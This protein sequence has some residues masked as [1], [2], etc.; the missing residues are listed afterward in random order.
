M[1]L[2]PL[3]HW[4]PAGR[5]DV[6]RRDGL[7]PGSAPT[8]ASVAQPHICLS[9]DPGTAWNVSGAREWVSE[10]DAWDLWLVRIDVDDELHMRSMF[11][12]R[13]EEI[14]VRSPI[15]ADRLWWVG[16]RAGDG[17]TAL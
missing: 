4:S 2:N 13:I 3:Y 12:P 7:R 16:R 17:V 9:T 10:V 8:V 1:L 14:Q 11:G 6:I 15:P 5:F